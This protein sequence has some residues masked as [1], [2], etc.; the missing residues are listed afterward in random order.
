VLRL[1]L[2]AL[3]GCG[4]KTANTAPPP[5]PPDA[6][7]AAGSG[8]ND[9]VAITPDA[10]PSPPGAL[11]RDLP[12]L[13]QKS[14]AL[15]EGVVAAFRTAGA[16]CAAA[17]KQLGELRVTYAD[18][19]VANAK[20]LHEGRA[21]ELKTALAKYEDKLAAAAKEISASQTMA[22]CT[23]DRAF[24]KAFDDLVGSPP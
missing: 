3:V 24:T 15:Y 19:G 14:L 1:V 13:A 23:S 12:R 6:A 10:P 17:T 5:P 18:V 21:R 2:I 4:P 16:N 7:I 9:P 8:A 22:K 20:V 11:D